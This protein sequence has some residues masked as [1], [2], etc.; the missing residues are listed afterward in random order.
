MYRRTPADARVLSG[1][2]AQD[3]AR[4]RDA[5]AKMCR[6]QASYHEQ[7]RKKWERAVLRPWRGVTPDPPPPLKLERSSTWDVSY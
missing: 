6:D 1:Q 4:Q 2:A 3:E 7:I 5:L